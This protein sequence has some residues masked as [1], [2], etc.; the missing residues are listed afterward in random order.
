[1]KGKTIRKTVY[2]SITWSKFGVE[3]LKEGKTSLNQLS[4]ST[5]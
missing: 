3:G 1:M 2:N 5:R 4:M